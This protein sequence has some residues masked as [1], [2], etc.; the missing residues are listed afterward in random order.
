MLNLFDSISEV[1]KDFFEVRSKLSSR[2]LTLFS[3]V[4]LFMFFYTFYL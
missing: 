1:I 4:G 2:F 3:E